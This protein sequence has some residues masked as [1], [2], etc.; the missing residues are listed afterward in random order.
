MIDLGFVIS[1]LLFKFNGF[2]RTNARN[3]IRGPD[4]HQQR[5]KERGNI[6]QDKVPD[7]E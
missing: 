1:R 2:G 5:N 7:M 6:Q 3:Y 4:K